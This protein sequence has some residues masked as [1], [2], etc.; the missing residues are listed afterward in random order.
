MDR[1]RGGDAGVRGA[2]VLISGYCR[3]CKDRR[4]EGGCRR[5]SRICKTGWKGPE[6]GRSGRCKQTRDY[7]S[8]TTSCGSENLFPGILTWGFKQI[9]KNISREKGR[10]RIILKK[11]AM[12][13]LISFWREGCFQ[14]AMVMLLCPRH[15]PFL[16][17]S[18]CYLTLGYGEWNT[19]IAQILPFSFCPP[20]LL[21]F[22]LHWGVTVWWA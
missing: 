5:K 10:R 1:G 14:P 22:F 19:Q 7:S 3:E 4:W 2:A 8:P 16:C 17:Q 6:S 13:Y 20:P 9:L 15:V 18:K 12:F 21:S 11:S